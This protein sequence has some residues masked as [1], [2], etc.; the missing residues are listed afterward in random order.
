[1]CD[2]IAN[3]LYIKISF[4]IDCPN[5]CT[6]H[7]NCLL[8]FIKEHADDEING[9]ICLA[10]FQETETN[11]LEVINPSYRTPNQ[12]FTPDQNLYGQSKGKEA[13]SYPKLICKLLK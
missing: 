4:Q 8:D 13:M 12:A 6:F 10:C 11:W 3:E 5:Q 7:S 2:R 9:N 1:M